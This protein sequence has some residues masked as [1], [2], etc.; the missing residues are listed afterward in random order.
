MAKPVIAVGC[1]VSSVGKGEK[2]E[3]AFVYL[4]Y[5]ESLR[6]SG[7]VPVLIPPQP[8]NASELSLEVDGILL[9]G[10][11]DCDPT[12]Y[13]EKAHPS[14][15]LMDRRRQE[16]D[17]ALARLAHERRIPTLGVCLGAQLMAIV[18]GGKLVQDIRAEFPNALRHESESTDRA[19]HEVNVF[20]GTR[21]AELVGAG[22][23]DV[24]STHHQ[25][26]RTVGGTFRIAAEAPDGIVEAIEDPTHPFYIGVQWHPED[27]GG[28]TSA[29]RLFAGF[30]EAARRH[31][32][33]RAD[34]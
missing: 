7:A 28:E 15:E 8:E 25:S 22:A 30:V 19:R 11:Y 2:R 10:G 29:D 24:N 14:V 9:A 32:Q 5:V 34:R 18:S 13:G 20:P 21:V 31:R 17:L 3:R 4:S 26:V 12:C 27:M 33:A 6:R 23:L 1:D 16:G